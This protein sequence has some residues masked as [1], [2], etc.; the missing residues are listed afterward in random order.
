MKLTKSILT[1]VYLIS[2]AQLTACGPAPEST[3]AST[4]QAQQVENLKS[5][6]EQANIEVQSTEAGQPQTSTDKTDEQ[7][8][9]DVKKRLEDILS[10]LG[11]MVEKL[12]ASGKEVPENLQKATDAAIAHVEGLLERLASD[13]EFQKRVIEAARKISQA[14]ASGQ[15]PSAGDRTAICNSVK[16]RL[17][18]DTSK[19]PAQVL[20]HMKSFVEKFCN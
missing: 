7:I 12:K 14:I 8:L 3:Q 15:V 18:G 13:V 2:T 17:E 10:K 19:I 4:S 20:E 11:T 16:V 5:A 1:I 6:I 9:A